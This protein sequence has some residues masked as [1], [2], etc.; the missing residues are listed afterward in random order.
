MHIGEATKPQSKGFNQITH[1]HTLPRQGTNLQPRNIDKRKCA[2]QHL[3]GK[4][5]VIKSIG[6]S[7]CRERNGKKR[8]T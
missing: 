3:L 6:S 4:S 5:S 8:K 1:T 2:S 7:V